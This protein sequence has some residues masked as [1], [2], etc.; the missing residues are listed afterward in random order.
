MLSRPTP[1]NYPD[2]YFRSYP[3]YSSISDSECGDNANYN[4]LQ[5]TF[6]R[7]MWRG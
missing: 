7:R 2:D 4:S 3:V 6:N 5:V 1:P